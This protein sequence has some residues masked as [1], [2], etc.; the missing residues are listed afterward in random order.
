MN[1]SVPFIAV[2]F[3]RQSLIHLIFMHTTRSGLKC[4]A[5]FRSLHLSLCLAEG[6]EHT[7]TMGKKAAEG[8]ETLLV[9]QRPKS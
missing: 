7:T 3:S 8:K 5:A 6:W 4:T 2:C 9:S 1:Q